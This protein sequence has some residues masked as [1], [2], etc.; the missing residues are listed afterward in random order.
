MTVS[1]LLC[2]LICFFFNLSI[3]AAPDSL[4]SAE[5]ILDTINQKLHTIIPDINS[6]ILHELNSHS[7]HL[8]NSTVSNTDDN[9][10]EV[11][12]YYKDG[13]TYGPVPDHIK[14]FMYGNSYKEDCSVPWSDLNY[15]NVQYYNFNHSVESGEI[16]CNKKISQD[17]IEIFY[18]LYC[19]EY[20]IEHIQLVDHY[21]ADD[22]LSME[23][24]NTSCFNYRTV[25]GKKTLSKHS[26]G[27]AID[28]NPFFNP[29][30]TGLSTGS[31]T[32][33]P[34]GSDQYADRNAEFL[35]KI[36]KNDLCYQLFVSHGFTWGGNWNSCKDYQHFEKE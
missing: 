26:Q 19:N 34:L 14:S 13:F 4:Q 24:N 33:T 21:M 30:V 20:E 3:Q 2:L 16:I 18:D 23:D 29:Y 6:I 15:L 7:N 10:S 28:I 12:T 8:N 27:L 25:P 36:T 17:L 5:Q 22:E 31:I 11:M 35:H 9:I 32:I 1:L